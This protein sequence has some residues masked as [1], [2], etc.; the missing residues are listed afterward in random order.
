MQ[1]SIPFLRAWLDGSFLPIIHH[2]PSF[3]SQ[4]SEHSQFL[5]Q[6]TTTWRAVRSNAI[7]PVLYFLMVTSLAM[8]VMLLIDIVFMAAGSLA[9]KLLRRRPQNRYKCDPINV[10]LEQGRYPMVLVQIPMYNEKEVYRL[11]IGAACRLTW[12]SD[13]IIIQV[14]DDSTDPTVKDLVQLECNNWRSNEKNVM[15]EVRDN[16]KGYKA[17]ALK[18]GMQHDYAQECEF[19]AIF[20]ADFQPDPDFLIKTIPFL[21]HSPKLG[22]VQACWQFRTC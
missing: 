17:G 19:V 2:F 12:P 11:S 21:V 9:V 10:D 5:I 6:T 22:L 1:P 16:R 8:S 7:A 15:Y 20:D 13:R 4:W 3:L 14:L 18:Q